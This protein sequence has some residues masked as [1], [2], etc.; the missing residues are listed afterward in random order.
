MT[1]PLAY[2]IRNVRERW[3]VALLAVAGIALVVAVF[4]ILTAMSQGFAT[5]PSGNR[6]R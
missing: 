6:P 5:A 2:N 1:L 4:V 3:T